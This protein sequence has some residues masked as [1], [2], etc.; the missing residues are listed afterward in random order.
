ML[1][2]KKPTQKG[3][4]GGKR[5]ANSRIS[6]FR[7]KAHDNRISVFYLL[8]LFQHLFPIF[9]NEVENSD[10]RALKIKDEIFHST[11]KPFIFLKT[12]VIPNIQLYF[13]DQ[14]ST[15]GLKSG[16]KRLG[17]RD[18]IR[19]IEEGRMDIRTNPLKMAPHTQEQ[20]IST[21]WNRPYSRE[22]AA[23]PAVSISPRV[24]I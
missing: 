1:C 7:I 17:I 19:E 14:A 24:V 15:H 23:F 12:Q 22:Q 3:K 11:R 5:W 8:G 4:I 10:G 20:V 21:E 2:L 18:E 13:N 9:F 6:N 16:T